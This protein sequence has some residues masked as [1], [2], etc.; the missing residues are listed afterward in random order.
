MLALTSWFLIPA[1]FA[2]GMILYGYWRGRDTRW[3][4]LPLIFF[5]LGMV[6]SCK[7]ERGWERREEIAGSLSKT[8]V[9]AKGK[10]TSL[11]EADGTLKITLKDNQVWKLGYKGKRSADSFS[12]KGLMVSVKEDSKNEKGGDSTRF[13]NLLVGQIILVKGEANLFSRARNPGEFDSKSFYQVMDL[14]MKLYGEDIVIV[15]SRKDPILEG[16]R[17]VK[18]WI[19]GIFYRLTGEKEAGIF[20]AAVIGDKEGIPKE[21]ND[22]Y[23]KNGIAHLLA[24]SGM[25]MSVIGLFFYN[26]LRKMGLSYGISGSISSVLVILY[27]ILTGGSPS[28]ER[29]VIMMVIAFLASY[30]G[31]TYD[32]LSS[33]ALALILLA[34]KSPLILMQGGVQLSFGA[35]FAIGGIMPLMVKWVGDERPFVRVISASIAIQMITLP[36]VL[37]HFYQLPLY[38]LFLNFIAIPLMD[39]VVYSGLAVIFI[40][41][42]CPI[43]GTAAAGLGN[44]ILIFYEFACGQI[45]KLPYYNLTFGRPNPQRIVAYIFFLVALFFLLSI[46]TNPKPKKTE[47]KSNSPSISISLR[48]ILLFSFYGICILLFKPAPVSGLEANFLDVGQGDGILLRTGTSAVLIDG[49]SSSKK[50]LGKYTLEPCLKNLGVSVIDYAFVSHGDLDH[51]SGVRFLLEESKDIKITTIMLPYHGKED[52]KI[53]ELEV[54]ANKRGT[55]VKYLAGGEELRVEGL[56]ISCLYPSIED[57]P[58]D[59]NDQSEVLKMDFGDCHMLFTGDMGEKGEMKLLERSKKELSVINVLKTAHHGSK[60]SSCAPFL[61]AVSPRFSIISYGE[62]NTYGH[63][64]KEVMER[65]EE[66]DVR[67]FETAKSGAIRL[68]TDGSNIQFTGFVDEE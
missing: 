14:D 35:V 48:L 9:E 19:I 21:I 56:K 39:A 13:K 47:E 28:V 68:W 20:V 42:V 67:V 55:K 40:G 10:I 4:L 18:L 1:F 36:V 62:N 51:I 65:L 64:H 7:Y 26:I 66:R 11:E 33:A 2:A 16:I 43:L 12:V 63:P 45:S 23:Q 15:D 37:Y 60:Y 24:I 8:Y 30:L 27:G 54:L 5:Y 31:R 58:E 41:S 25:H 3:V 32:L 59:V 50:T 38:G 53:K 6:W 46:T 44:Y 57:V 22:L 49:G 17:Q 52:E 61:D 29:A 34:V